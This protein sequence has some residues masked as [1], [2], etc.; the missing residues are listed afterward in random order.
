MKSTRQPYSA[1][2]FVMFILGAGV[3]MLGSYLGILTI[4][5]QTVVSDGNEAEWQT[6]EI[7]GVITVEIPVACSIDP[8]AGNH[9]VVCPTAENP[10]PTPELN[11]SSDGTTVN[12]RRWEGL[13]TPYWEHVVA[14]MNVVQPMERA[15]TINIEK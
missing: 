2:P 13:D 8:G 6:V 7:S 12:V 9:Y 5:T 10:T 15:I 1:F 14:S 3:A 11:I 4:G